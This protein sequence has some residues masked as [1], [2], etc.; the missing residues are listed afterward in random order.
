MKTPDPVNQRDPFWRVQVEIPDRPGD[1]I[2]RAEIQEYDILD[3]QPNENV[4]DA[5]AHV[6]YFAERAAQ[7][8]GPHGLVFCFEPE[9]ENFERLVVRLQSRIVA[10]DVALSDRDGTAT[11]H[12]HSL[13]SGSHSL[14]WPCPGG[15]SKVVATR[16]LDS[17]QW[18][19]P[20]HAMK[21]DVEG[22][23]AALLRGAMDLLRRDHPRI[24]MEV[25]SE[26]LYAE[27]RE[28]L[29]PLGYGFTPEVHPE[30]R[31]ITLAEVR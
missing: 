19:V 31:W 5:G 28:L 10:Y 12:I 17:F 9:S 21:I 27:V 8:V 23:E 1:A 20:I 29:E 11:L 2:V 4:I 26:A 14:C 13:G 16:R 18:P 3:L 24:A 6:G 25:H 22:S 30:Q 15:A 7:L